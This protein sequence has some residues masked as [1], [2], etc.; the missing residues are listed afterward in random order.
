MVQTF[1]AGNVDILSKD[2]PF[3]ER[4]SRNKGFV[5]TGHILVQF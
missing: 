3:S 2:D 1:F 5:K 4:G